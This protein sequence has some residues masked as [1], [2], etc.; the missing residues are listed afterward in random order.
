M[1]LYALKPTMSFQ[2]WLTHLSSL[3]LGSQATSFS[4]HLAEEG[5]I[6]WHKVT[7]KLKAPWG[8]SH[9]ET[10]ATP[11]SKITF[12]DIKKVFSRL[13]GELFPLSCGG[14]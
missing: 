4:Q 14:N 7:T 11:I 8:L 9:W 1:R 13:R 10:H 5:A 6:V 3:W 2:R 12:D